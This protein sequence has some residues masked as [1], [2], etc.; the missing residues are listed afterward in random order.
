MPN[1]CKEVVGK[2]SGFYVNEIFKSQLSDW[3]WLGALTYHK[4]AM[5][6]WG[7][8]KGMHGPCAWVVAKNNQD[9]MLMKF[10]K[11]SNLIGCGGEP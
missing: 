11:A 3:Q 1:L 2:K 6:L 7:T 5:C 9:F 8:Y 10:L 4:L